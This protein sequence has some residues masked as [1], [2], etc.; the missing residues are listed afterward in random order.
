MT[1]LRKATISEFANL[2][3]AIQAMDVAGLQ[4][5]LI[6][7]QTGR[8][9]GIITDGDLR[10]AI[11]RGLSYDVRAIDVANCRPVVARL[12]ISRTAALSIMRENNIAHLPLVDEAGCVV[13]LETMWEHLGEVS[14]TWAVVMAGGLG[15]RLA[16]LTDAVPKPL[17]PVGGQPIIERIVRSLIASGIRR[18]FLSVNYRA[19][20]IRSHFGDGGEFGVQIEYLHEAEPRGTA[21][22]LSGLPEMPP[23]QLLVMNGDIL[24]GIDFG[25]LLEFHR[26]HG[27]PATMCIR[28][29]KVLID[30]G[31]VQFDG[32]YISEI[33]E[34]PFHSCFI[35]AGI[36]V[37]G[38]HAL[39]L[40][41]SEG[42]YDMPA[43]FKKLV[44]DGLRPGVFPVREFWLDIGTPL[45]YRRAQAEVE[46]VTPACPPAPKESGWA[47]DRTSPISR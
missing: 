1:T 46:N 40:I 11:L 3:A 20:M 41:P 39:S 9:L 24:T 10:R 16:P 36:Y 14:D 21:G 23:G 28:E 25:S 7:G 5:V 12:P 2:R 44:S 6:E 26:Q 37:L 18:I 32:P 17:L 22:A 27:G 15:T 4:I 13:G 29:H 38:G 34:K 30:Y 45:D 8:L 42:R 33:V 31:V 47:A 35:N 19:E 43:L